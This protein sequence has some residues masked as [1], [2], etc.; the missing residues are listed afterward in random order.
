ME[1]FSTGIGSKSK[2]CTKFFLA[3]LVAHLGRAVTSCTMSPVASVI[4]VSRHDLEDHK[5]KNEVA[6]DLFCT[7]VVSHSAYIFLN[8]EG[9]GDPNLRQI[10]WSALMTWRF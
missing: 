7:G 10:D 8:L 3:L 4:T 5:N 1:S 6:T 2:P 9:Y